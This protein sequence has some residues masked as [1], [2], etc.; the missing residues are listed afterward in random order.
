MRTTP[1]ILLLSTALTTSARAQPVTAQFFGDVF[2]PARV[3]VDVFA[4]LRPLLTEATFN[5]VNF[6]GAATEAFV[7]LEPKNFLLKMP[8]SVAAQLRAGKIDAVTLANNHSMDFGL[9]GLHDTLHALDE[10][11][12]AHAGAGLD[13]SGA[14]APALLG[15][16]GT[17]IC[18]L[19]FSRTLPQIFWAKD[20]SPGTA[21]AGAPAVQE[22]VR[23]C[24]DRGFFTAV[25]FHW[26]KEGDSSP[27]PYQK[28]LA[29]V[30]IDAGADAV[31]GHHPH[32]VQDIEV[33]NGKPIFHSLGNFV[34]GSLPGGR[35]PTG[36]GVR[37]TVP[38]LSDGPPPPPTWELIPL[39]VDN[40]HVAYQ[41]RP[42]TD[43]TTFHASIAR[44]VAARQCTFDDESR[45]WTCRFE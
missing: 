37:V 1:K 17:T 14:S 22:A 13:A 2:I 7:P 33:Y 21:F 40:R 38:S 34:F 16:G 6:E 42:I 32:V 26:G 41:P 30:A 9:Q 25:T 44:L 19:A 35:G 8:L 31:I 11:G 43:K 27:A 23:A 29:R 10:A 36:L 28:A 24:K 4:H 12:I 18:V 20:Q 45:R 15:A 39:N 5:V 3:T